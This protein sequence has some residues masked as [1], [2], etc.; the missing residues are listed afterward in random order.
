MMGPADFDPL[1]HAYP[2]ADSDVVKRILLV[3]RLLWNTRA[4]AYEYRAGGDWFAAYQRRLVED[5]DLL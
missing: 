2:G 1:I 5:L 3:Y 4:L